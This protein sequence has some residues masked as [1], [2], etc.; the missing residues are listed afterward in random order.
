M[1]LVFREILASH[2]GT[3]QLHYLYPT[4]H[5]SG[6]PDQICQLWVIGYAWASY[7]DQ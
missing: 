2:A 3:V 6:V 1:K 7:G 5:S 4:V